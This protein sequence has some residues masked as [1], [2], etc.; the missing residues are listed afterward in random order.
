[1][2]GDESSSV[3]VI[4]ADKHI[5]QTTLTS[6]KHQQIPVVSSEWVVQCLIAGRR[7][8]VI[9]HVKYLLNAAE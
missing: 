8:S 3:D 7:L 2:T 1:L 4:V 6:A 9:G 5:S